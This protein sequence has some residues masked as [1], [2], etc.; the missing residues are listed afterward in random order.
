MD[1]IHDYR[2]G[3]IVTRHLEWVMIILYI[4]FLGIVLMVFCR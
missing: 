2:L 1:L 4:V 3:F